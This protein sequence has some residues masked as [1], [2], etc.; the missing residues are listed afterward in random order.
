MAFPDDRSAR[1]RRLVLGAA[2]L[3]GLGRAARAAEPGV[4]DDR[5][6]VGQSITLQ[7]G[8]NLYAAQVQAGVAAALEDLHRGGG[9]NG[10]RVE[11]RTLD[12]ANDT[13]RAEANAR[14]LVADGAFVLFGSLEGGPSTAV[15]KAALDLKVPFIGP[16]AGS[17]GLRRPHQPLVFPV[18]AEHREEFRAL[19]EHGRSL[20]LARVALFHADSD[21]GREHLGNVERLAL[22]TG[23]GFGGGAPFRADITDEQLGAVV[24]SLGGRGVDLVLNHVSRASNWFRDF[25]LGIAPSRD[26]F[27]TEDPAKDLRAVVRPRTH[28]LLTPVKTRD[29]TRHV[30]T[31]F[32]EDQVDLNYANPDVLFEMLDLL[33]VYISMVPPI[34]GLDL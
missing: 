27:I 28:P 11:L 23:L 29:R 4:G 26:F 9:L 17:P 21:V 20:G 16:M 18:R 3:V 2:A 33:L 30:W 32:S 14:R 7:G 5:I 1:R 15:M 25:E 19:M 31:T 24:A 34:I 13:A 8:R 6:V 12:D 10:R 22:E